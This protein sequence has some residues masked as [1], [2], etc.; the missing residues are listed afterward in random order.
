MYPESDELIEVRYDQIRDH[1]LA[2]PVP[3]GKSLSVIIASHAAFNF[4]LPKRFNA[5]EESA[6]GLCYCSSFQVLVMINADGSREAP[7]V[8]EEL[9]DD[10]I[11]RA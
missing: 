4:N 3:A 11:S 7:I 9:N 6:M 8:I 10:Y 2:Y 1:L 5:K